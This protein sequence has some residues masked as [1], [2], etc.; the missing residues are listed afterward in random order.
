MEAPI[1]ESKPTVKYWNLGLLA[2][3]LTQTIC[4]GAD[5]GNPKFK[6]AVQIGAERLILNGSG[7]R[8]ATMFKVKV[9]EAALYLKAKS[10]DGPTV[11]KAPYPKQLQMEFLRDFEGKDMQTAWDHSFAESCE[12]ACE[13]Q[14]GELEKLKN[15][16]VTVK[17]GDRMTYTFFENKVE[18][19]FNGEKKGEIVSKTFPQNL[20]ATWIGKAPPTEALRRGLLGQSE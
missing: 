20:L 7:L 2:L 4:Q 8:T 15:L 6:D 17:S 18:V 11:L 12:L 19:A 14:S 5:S 9:Y 13:S 10:T 16:M 1:I 3:L